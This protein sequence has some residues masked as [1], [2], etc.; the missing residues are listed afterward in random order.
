VLVLV[1]AVLGGLAAGT[2]RPP[3]GA[4]GLRIRVRGLLLLAAGA[5]G[6]ALA[7][8]LEGDL[9]TLALAAS[10]TTLLGF[11]AIN[12]HVTGIMVIGCG[13]LLN[14]AAVVLNNGMPVRPGALVAAGVLDEADLATATLAG[15]RHLETPSDT[16]GVLGDALPLPLAREAVSFGDLIVVAGTLDA[17]RELARR[18]RP[19]WS[20]AQRRSYRATTTQASVA[21]DWGAAPS[22]APDDGSQ[23]SAKPDRR[24]PDTNDV[25]SSSPAPRSR[26]L[27]VV[28]QSK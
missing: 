6:S 15:P 2:L 14:L 7:Q 19:A 22:A 4:R 18:R 24:A 28:S 8:V 26:R 11:V 9:A 12:A 21:H 17:V 5:F 27:V 16:F 23:Y 20:S 25:A 13:L 3:I 10:L 1:V